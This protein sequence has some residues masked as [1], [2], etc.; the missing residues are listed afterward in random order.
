MTCHEVDHIILSYSAG[1]PVSPELAAHI[2]GC[3]RCRPL[4]EAL[5]Q[6]SEPAVPP[7][8]GVQRVQQSILADLRPVKP[9]PSSGALWIVSVAVLALVAAAGTLVLGHAGWRARG[10]LQR[11]GMFSVVVLAAGLTGASAVRQIVPGTRIFFPALS[12][13][14]AALLALVAAS[15]SLF[16]PHA[17]A[18]FANGVECLVIGTACATVCSLLLWL[19]LRRGATMTPVSTGATVGA[20]AGLSGV[21]V[22]EIFCPNLNRNHILVWHLGA[23]LVSVAVCTIAGALAEYAGSRSGR[24]D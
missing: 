20:L 21:A 23:V 22:L 24:T 17:E 12:I 14:V 2:A 10:P 15:T 1:A 6:L 3:D 7:S 9:L 19:V 8:D 18:A 13:V 4:A 5:G 11:F 16:A